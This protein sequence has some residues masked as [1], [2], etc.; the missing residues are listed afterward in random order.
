MAAMRKTYKGETDTLHK[1]LDIRND[2]TTDFPIH[3]RMLD[4]VKAR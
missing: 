4:N 1:H 3:I 2:D